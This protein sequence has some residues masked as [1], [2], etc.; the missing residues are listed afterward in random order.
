MEKRANKYFIHQIRI[1]EAISRLNALW[2]HYENIKIGQIQLWEKLKTV[3]M[4]IITTA[5]NWPKFGN[6]GGSHGVFKTKPW[7]WNPAGNYNTKFLRIT[8][9]RK[10][11]DPFSRLCRFDVLLFWG[12]WRIFFCF[13]SHPGERNSPIADFSRAIYSCIVCWFIISL[14]VTS[15]DLIFGISFV[16]FMY[17]RVFH[18]KHA[19]SSRLL[20]KKWK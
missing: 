5:S 15:H 12:F 8:S 9:F 18:A 17:S 16:R 2:C 11:K 1:H 6:A 4:S 3:W 13:E 7:Q 20:Y 10:L 19:L 14:L